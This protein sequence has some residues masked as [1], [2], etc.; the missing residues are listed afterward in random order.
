MVEEDLS[1][2]MI[3]HHGHWCRHTLKKLLYN[4]GVQVY[5]LIEGKLFVYPSLLLSNHLQV[6]WCAKAKSKPS[7]LV[8]PFLLLSNHLQVSWDT[9]AFG[10]C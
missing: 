6:S 4:F 9:F 5:T 10:V 8:Y 3:N 7:F 1:F 2:P